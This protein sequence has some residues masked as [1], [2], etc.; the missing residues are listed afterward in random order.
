M[1]LD[2]FHRVRRIAMALSAILVSA[3]GGGGAAPPPPVSPGLVTTRVS[4]PTPFAPNCNGAAQTGTLYPDA[5]VEPY[6]AINPASPANLIG[7]WQQDRW[8][9]GSSQGLGL[10][11][12]FDGGQN[13]ALRATPLFSRCSG[14]VAGS[15]GDYQRATD[16]WVSIAPDGT[17]HQIALGATGGV[18][19]AGSASAILASRSVDGGSTWSTPIAL[20][21]DGMQFFNDKESI[22]ADRTSPAFVYAT[23]DRIAASGGGPTYFARTVDGG[24]SWQPARAI[25][26]PGT[27]SQTIGNR[28][29]VLPDGTLVLA[30]TQIDQAANGS[31]TAFYAVI[32]SADHGDTWSAPIR[33]ADAM[34]LGARDPDTGAPIRDGS[35]LTEIAAG[36]NGQLAMV[37]Q[38]ARFSSGQVD[39]IA[40]SRSS[41]GGLTWSV[42]FRVNGAPAFA[43]FTPT[44]FIADNGSYGVSYYDFRENTSDNRTLPTSYWL[45]VSPDAVNW[46]ERKID[47]PFDLAFA[48]NAEGLFLGDYQSGVQVDTDLLLFFVRTNPDLANRTDV[49]SVRT[50]FA[51][52]GTIRQ[53]TA[54]AEPLSADFAATPLF[55]ARVSDM[56]EREVGEGRQ[57]RRAFR[58][59]R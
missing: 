32:R 23:W 2:R 3:C 33:V 55:K 17:A 50:P 37:W 58:K 4:G 43:A 5:E 40:F 28:I 42:P 51:P 18:F 27:R 11:V 31:F 8:S 54:K 21:A 46:S 7:V 15:V 29:V 45:T 38:D 35:T 10:A 13:W 22:T 19:Q 49:R 47:G 48:P 26:D 56:L 14:A 53:A 36:T 30:F 41:D 1:R 16:P 25:Y 6:V 44:I 9:N 12:S 59:R 57:P 24:L 20:I 34:A 52:A 39:G